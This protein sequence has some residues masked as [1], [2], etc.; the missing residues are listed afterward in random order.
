[1]P[2]IDLKSALKSEAGFL[3]FIRSSYRHGT[4]V[5]LCAGAIGILNRRLEAAVA[6]KD[7]DGQ[8]Y[9]YTQIEVLRSEMH[10]RLE[11]RTD[12]ALARGVLH[13]AGEAALARVHDYQRE[14]YLS[15]FSK[16]YPEIVGAVGV[17]RAKFWEAG[18]YGQ[19]FPLWAQQNGF[20]DTQL[21]Q[22]IQVSKLRAYDALVELNRELEENGKGARS[23]KLKTEWDRRRKEIKLL[24]DLQFRSAIYKCIRDVLGEG[25]MPELEKWMTLNTRIPHFRKLRDRSRDSKPNLKLQL[26][27]G[28]KFRPERTPH[29]STVSSE[30]RA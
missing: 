28:R 8:R 21:L 22:A 15:E 3:E 20:T 17:I 23:W 4:V 11:I 6:R 2:W 30:P 9:L 14:R 25:F 12:Q 13:L 27:P 18:V 5:A 19:D 29:Q 1:M 16:L 24:S 10:V 7:R 26:L